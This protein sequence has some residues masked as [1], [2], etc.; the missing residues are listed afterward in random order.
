MSYTEDSSSISSCPRILIEEWYDYSVTEKNFEE[1]SNFFQARTQINSSSRR[2]NVADI[3]YKIIKYRTNRRPLRYM[4]YTTCAH[5]TNAAC[6]YLGY[7]D[8]IDTSHASYWTTI[9]NKLNIIEI[10]TYMFRENILE[11]TGT[12]K[13]F[14]LP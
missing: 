3:C 8:R 10:F 4:T 7:E 2:A 6:I 13:K 1:W 12:L 14:Q 11:D 9:E 5:I